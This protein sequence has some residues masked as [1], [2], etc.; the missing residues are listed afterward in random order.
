MNHKGRVNEYTGMRTKSIGWALVAVAVA[1][2]VVDAWTHFDLAH[3]YA[4][5]RTSTVNEGVLF[6]I[7]ASAA[8]VAAVWLLVQRTI[9]SIAFTILVTAG[10]AF[11]LLLYNYVDVGKI[12][13]IPDM[14]DPFWSGEKKLA[15]A[16]ELVAL[17]AALVLL[18]LR[19]RSRRGSR[20]LVVA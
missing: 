15:L 12:G 11:A 2:L 10:G 6:R 8:V 5:I 1:G 9:L 17:A 7:E 13:P 19:V 4:P 3:V 18:G 20:P 14:Y 16:G